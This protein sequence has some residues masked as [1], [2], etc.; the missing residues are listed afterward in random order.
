MSI[1]SFWEGRCGVQ[2]TRVN[3]QL[4]V[5]SEDFENPLLETVS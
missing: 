1:G 5:L 3:F 2:T 4:F